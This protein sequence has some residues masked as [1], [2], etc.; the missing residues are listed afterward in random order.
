M[1]KMTLIKENDLESIYSLNGL[2][3][4][5]NSYAVSAADGEEILGICF[6]SINDTICKI[7]KISCDD[8]SIS[9]GITRASLNAALNKGAINAEISAE[10]LNFLKKKSL[11]YENDFS[12][13]DFF[14]CKNCR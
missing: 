11:S 2:D 14:E 13:V 8:A 1:I 10:V 6:F 12:I 4:S 3:F 5:E 7:Q 9:D